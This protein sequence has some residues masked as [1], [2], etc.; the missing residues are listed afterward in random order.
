MLVFEKKKI[1]RFIDLGW[2]NPCLHDLCMDFHTFSNRVSKWVDP[3]HYKR[4]VHVNSY[5]HLNG[6]G[7]TWAGVLTWVGSQPGFM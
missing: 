5:R 6:E 2:L 3:G 7:L 1:I 4:W